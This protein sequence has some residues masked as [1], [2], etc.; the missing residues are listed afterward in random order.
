MTL[1]KNWR[2]MPGMR[3]VAGLLCTVVSFG[4]SATEDDIISDD[5]AN[6]A[7]DLD[8]HATLGCLQLGLLPE[9]WGAALGRRVEVEVMATRR[10]EQDRLVPAYVARVM[11][12]CDTWRVHWSSE[13]HPTK[14][15]SLLACLGAV[16]CRS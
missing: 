6:P 3:D 11:V 14:G 5:P 12:W 7:P 4:T 15:E 2:W 8:D 16:P 1:P 9:L 13:K 10:F